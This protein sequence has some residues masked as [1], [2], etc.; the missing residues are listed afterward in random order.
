[1]TVYDQVQVKKALQDVVPP[2]LNVPEGELKRLDGRIDALDVKIDSFRNEL[3]ARVESLQRE[4]YESPWRSG[5]DWP[6]W[7]RK[8]G[9]SGN[10]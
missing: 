8:S 10:R 7:R 5:C 6:P 3:L 1:M 4:V 2:E 9:S